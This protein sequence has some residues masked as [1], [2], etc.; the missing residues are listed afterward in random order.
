[1]RAH[2]PL[3]QRI[4]AQFGELAPDAFV[5][6]AGVL[7]LGG[8]GLLEVDVDVEAAAGAVGYGVGEGGVGGGFLR[9]GGRRVDEG[10]GVGAGWFLGA[11]W[12]V[13]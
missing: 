8:G 10:F 3:H 13:V 11:G 6:F 9:F 2:G 5:Q 7:D 4:D 1:V 12:L